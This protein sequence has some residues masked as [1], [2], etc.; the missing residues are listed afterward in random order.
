MDY[1]LATKDFL[2]KQ[3]KNKKWRVYYYENIQG[4]SGGSVVNGTYIKLGEVI[5]DHSGNILSFILKEDAL[6]HA[7]EVK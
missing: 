3:M 7:K 1:E 6:R 2:I 4:V 5:R